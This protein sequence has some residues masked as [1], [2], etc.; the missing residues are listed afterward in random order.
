MLTCSR[1]V[2]DD[3]DCLAGTHR[4]NGRTAVV[5]STV[6]ASARASAQ[7]I[8]KATATALRLQVL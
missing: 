5:M 2:A 8:L 3:S 4:D 7:A 1:S 6:P